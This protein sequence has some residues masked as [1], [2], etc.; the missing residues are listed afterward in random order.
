[1][2]SSTVEQ[3]IEREQMIAL[4]N[5]VRRGRNLYE[6]DLENLANGIRNASSRSHIANTLYDRMIP[7]L[8]KRSI[9]DDFD[10]VLGR[11]NRYT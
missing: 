4:A 3:R 2:G 11:I 10:T 9:S 7:T 6:N 5:G 8:N 1:M